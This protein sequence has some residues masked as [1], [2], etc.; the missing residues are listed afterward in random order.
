MASPKRGDDPELR[1]QVVANLVQKFATNT[2]RPRS[3]LRQERMAGT[4]T[5]RPS[6]AG[7]ARNYNADTVERT[8]RRPPNA[9]GGT[10]PI[11][12]N[13]GS[14]RASTITAGP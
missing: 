1:K 5:D 10:G 8:R 13:T 7:V 12:R 9:S 2:P 4:N 14:K 11:G 6:L 3:L